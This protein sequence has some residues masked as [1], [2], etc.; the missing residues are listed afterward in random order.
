[1]TVVSASLASVG[2]RNHLNTPGGQSLLNTQQLQ[3]LSLV[4]IPPSS[5]TLSLGNIIPPL[6]AVQGNRRGGKRA[7]VEGALVRWGEEGGLLWPGLAGW[8]CEPSSPQ[9]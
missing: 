6:G 5:N 9:P 7:G 4:G 2:I 3:F 8:A 1:M